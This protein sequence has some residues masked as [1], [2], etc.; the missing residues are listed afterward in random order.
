MGLGDG[1]VPVTSFLLSVR[2]APPAQVVLHTIIYSFVWTSF[3]RGAVFFSLR[4]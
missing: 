3:P 4:C 1:S 2:V